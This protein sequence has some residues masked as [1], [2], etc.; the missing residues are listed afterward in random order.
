M[1]R[2]TGQLIHRLA[3]NATPVHPLARP[4]TRAAAWLALSISY[5]VV[6]VFVMPLRH[7]ISS[8]LHDNIF[9]LEQVAA[10]A[11]GLTAAVAAFA[12]VV[13][14]YDNRLTLLP[15]L[16]LTVWISSLGPG[17]LHEFHQF[18]ITGL[19]LT[20]DPWCVPFI[21][22]LGAIPAIAIAVMLRRGAPLTPRLTAGLGG[23]AAAGLANAGVRI[24]HPED[25][26]VML[27]VWHVG[28]V[29][30]LSALAGAMG[31]YVLNWRS[32]LKFDA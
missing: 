9:I 18:G 27:L 10:F 2:D 23:L 22:L 32:V 12:S 14:G 13:P 20:H 6:L 1:T 19:P 7:D 28:S 3:E 24:I 15:L 21:I 25:V 31:H 4:Y 8:K 16:P 30:A 29:M 5:I 11:T 17:C 26:S